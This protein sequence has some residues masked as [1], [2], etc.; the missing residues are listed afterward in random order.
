[1][2]RWLCGLFRKPKRFEAV[3]ELVPLKREAVYLLII[4]QEQTGLSRFWAMAA[5]SA[6]SAVILQGQLRDKYKNLRISIERQNLCL[7]G[8]QGSLA[9]GELK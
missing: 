4:H 2:F 7:D 6:E 5:D 9:G 8:D 3:V 1:M